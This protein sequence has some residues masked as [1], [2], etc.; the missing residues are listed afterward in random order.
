M[1]R[2][3][4][5]ALYDAQKDM[6]ATVMEPEEI[7]QAFAALS[8]YGLDP[9]SVDRSLTTELHNVL[10]MRYETHTKTDR[11]NGFGWSSMHVRDHMLRELQRHLKYVASAVKA[12]YDNGLDAIGELPAILDGAERSKARYAD[13]AT[14]HQLGLSR[15]WSKAPDSEDESDAEMTSDLTGLMKALE[16][17]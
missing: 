5:D 1:F 4:L 9:D 8:E 6:L 17:P 14:A 7:E 12:F 3:A 2:K 13:P 11:L 10:A 16:S 15:D